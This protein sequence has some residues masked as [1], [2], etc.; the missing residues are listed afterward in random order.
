MASNQLNR[1][2]ILL[3]GAAAAIGGIDALA[4]GEPDLVVIFVVLAAPA[5]ALLV[6]SHPR[7][8][9]VA[10]RRDLATWLDQR[11]TATGETAEVLADR[12]VSTYRAGL[13][14][15]P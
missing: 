1:L 8:P 11:G 12:C 2:L 5:G 15:R 13:D 14:G 10:L 4:S 6:R 9:P 3:S 7:R